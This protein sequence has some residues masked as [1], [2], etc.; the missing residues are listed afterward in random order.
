MK[1]SDQERLQIALM[2]LSQMGR[3]VPARVRAGD[4]TRCLSVC[5]NTRSWNGSRGAERQLV[6]LELQTMLDSILAR[7]SGEAPLTPDR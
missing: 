7:S 1:L 2:S 3:R 6:P 5:T 4:T